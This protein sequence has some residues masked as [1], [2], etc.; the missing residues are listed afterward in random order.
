M[1]DHHLDYIEKLLKITLDPTIPTFTP[2]PCPVYL[3]MHY[4]GSTNVTLLIEHEWYLPQ[5]IKLGLMTPS[6]R[7]YSLGA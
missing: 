7:T 6:Q 4:Q 3:E 1:D 5:C 2:R